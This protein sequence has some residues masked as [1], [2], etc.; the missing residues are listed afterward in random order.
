MPLIPVACSQHNQAIP[1]YIA[2]TF[3][4]SVVDLGPGLLVTILLVSWLAA[5]AVQCVICELIAWDPNAAG[6]F[7]W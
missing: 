2:I 5:A 4:P 7:H 6:Q 3:Y 1:M